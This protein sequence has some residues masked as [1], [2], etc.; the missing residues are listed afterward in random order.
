MPLQVFKV[1]R[2]LIQYQGHKINNEIIN[3]LKKLVFWTAVCKRHLLSC[4]QR[5]YFFLIS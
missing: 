1:V 2:D 5:K 4:K 3:E